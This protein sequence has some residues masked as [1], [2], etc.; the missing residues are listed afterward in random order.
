MVNIREKSSL[1]TNTKKYEYIDKSKDKDKV[2][3]KVINPHKHT[4]GGDRCQPI[5]DLLIFKQGSVPWTGICD[6]KSHNDIWSGGKPRKKVFLQ[7][8][9]WL[10]KMQKHWF[11]ISMIFRQCRW[12]LSLSNYI[13]RPPSRGREC[14]FL[15]YCESD[16]KS[17]SLLGKSETRCCYFLNW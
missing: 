12:L 5:G 17:C 6:L 9:H 7:E 15:S 13:H 11:I 3:D 14:I 4:D 16:K 2:K 10:F 1:P 8:L